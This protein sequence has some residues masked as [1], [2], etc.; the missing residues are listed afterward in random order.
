MRQGVY[1]EIAPVERLSKFKSPI[2]MP[3][4]VGDLT[5]AGETDELEDEQTFIPG[6][7]IEAQVDGGAQHLIA[8]KLGLHTNIYDDKN[9]YSAINSIM[10]QRDLATS[11]TP[12]EDKLKALFDPK[13]FPGG[14]GVSFGPTAYTF[15]NKANSEL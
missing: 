10:P 2:A 1:S 5:K 11:Q 15:V 3:G 13:K 7:T 4:F 9:P 6:K 12:H 14:E 8:Q